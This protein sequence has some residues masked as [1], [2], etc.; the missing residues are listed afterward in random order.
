MLLP[1]RANIAMLLD[2]GRSVDETRSYARRWMLEDDQFVD[3]FLESLISDSWRPYE[4]CYAEALP[5]CRRFVRGDP[6]RFR[7]LLQEQ[8]VPGDL[9]GTG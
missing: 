9:D 2:D 7:R 5:L 4:S 1:V 8:L 3:G 6:G